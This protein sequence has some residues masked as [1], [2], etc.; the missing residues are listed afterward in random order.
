MTTRKCVILSCRMQ[1][2]QT[3]RPLTSAWIIVSASF[4]SDSPLRIAATC[5]ASSTAWA[6][7]ISQSNPQHTCVICQWY[8]SSI[9][10]YDW[11]CRWKRLQQSWQ[12]S[13]MWFTKEALNHNSQ[14]Q[15]KEPKAS[16]SSAATSL[17]PAGSS[18]NSSADRVKIC[19][20]VLP[21][22]QWKQNIES[23]LSSYNESLQDL[24]TSSWRVGKAF[25]ATCAKIV[26]RCLD[27]QHECLVPPGVEAPEIQGKN[28]HCN[29]RRGLS[30]CKQ[31]EIF[32]ASNDRGSP[33][34]SQKSILK[35][36]TQGEPLGRIEYRA[37]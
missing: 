27:S 4:K 5:C 8:V 17:N 28:G 13:E 37:Y 1:I 29:I 2:C 34:S 7:W 22:N 33:P 6:A 36:L 24:G 20:T 18:Q 35:T 31:S 16:H 26:W 3:T 14:S 11:V 15:A 10:E 23:F 9:S 21:F 30:C 25:P 19:P 12:Q 32:A